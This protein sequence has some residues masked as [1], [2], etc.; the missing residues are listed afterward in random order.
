MPQFARGT[1]RIRSRSIFTG[2][3]CAREAEPLRS[4]RTCVSTTTPCGSPS[5]A[6]TT[7]AVLRATPG[8][9]T[10][11]S[12]VRG[13]PPVVLLD[14]HPHRAAQRPRLLP[15]EA[16]RDRCRAGAPPRA[17]RGSPRAAGT[18]RKSVAVTRLTFTSVVCAESITATSSSSSVPR[19]QRDG[20]VRMRCPQPLDHGPMRSRFGPTRRRASETK[21]RANGGSQARARADDVERRAVRARALARRGHE[22]PRA[23]A[24][25]RR[26]QLRLE[27]RRV[28]AGVKTVTTGSSGCSRNW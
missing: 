4:R 28:G 8:S 11:S 19:A 25:D 24:R 3:S 17:R 9:R 5:S 23:D 12:T 13:H 26:R 14:Q 18:S 15:E 22:R 10:S 6:A 7:F 27:L 1:S 21:L 20:R 16:G 2:S